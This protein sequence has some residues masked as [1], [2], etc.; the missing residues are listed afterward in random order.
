MKSIMFVTVL[1]AFTFARADYMDSDG[2]V[3]VD[4]G[5]IRLLPFE[6]AV[7]ACPEGW[8]LPSSLEYALKAQSLGASIL[9]N[10]NNASTSP[11]GYFE[12]SAVNLDGSINQFLYSPLNYNSSS[13]SIRVEK[14]WSSSKISKYSNFAY[15]FQGDDGRFDTLPTNYIN[16]VRCIQDN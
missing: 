11:E 16:A 12:V 14:F 5:L 4:D 6:R 8:H 9:N 3:R 2:I 10:S 7:K 13:D 15:A 1:I